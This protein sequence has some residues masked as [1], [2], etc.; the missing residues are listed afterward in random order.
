M[1]ETLS[2]WLDELLQ[3]AVIVLMVSLTAVVISAVIWRKMGASFSWYDEVASVLLAWVTYYGA[4]L[5]ALRRGH[6]GFD[7]FLLAI[8]LPW[9]MVAVTVAELFVIGFFVI[10]AWT[11]VQVLRVLEGDNLVSL[12]WVPVALTQSVIPVG[13]ALFI[14]AELLS[15]PAYWRGVREGTLWGHEALP[16]TAG[17]GAAR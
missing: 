17:D 3:W 12:T 1:L 16:E 14:L 15:L 10:L 8:P 6:I 7:G 5:A 13:A 2:R 9:R 4:A 11:G